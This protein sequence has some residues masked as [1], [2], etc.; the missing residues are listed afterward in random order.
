[1]PMSD[2]RSPGGA[3]ARMQRATRRLLSL[4]AKLVAVT[5]AVLIVVSASLFVGLVYRERARLVDAK[6]GAA[7]MLVQLLASELAAALDFGDTDSIKARLDDL[8]TNPDIVGAAVW[9]DA[10]SEPAAAW[11]APGAPPL[12]P[13]LS[14]DPD[15]ATASSEWL[16]ATRTIVGPR[17]AALA[18]ARV[19]FSLFPE[20][21]A[22]RRSRLRLFWLTAGL[23]AATAVVLALLARRYVVGPVRRLASAATALADGDLSVRVDS[24][25]ADEIGELARAFNVMGSAVAYREERLHKEIELAQRIQT[26]ILPANLTVPALE[27]AASM[28][29][30]SE[31]GG[32]YYD[33]LPVAGGSW[34]G[35]GDVAGH[36]L[37][38]GLMMLMIQAVVAG[39]V[40]RDPAS[41]PKEVL[42]TLNEVLFDNIR[43]RLKR[44]DHATLTLLSYR[45]DGTIA[46]AGAHEDIVVYRADRRVCEVVATPGTW[47]GGRRDIR[48][49]TVESTLKLDPGDVVLLHTD[50]ATEIRNSRGEPFGIER[51]CAGLERGAGK[52]PRELVE[53]L[54]LEVGA[55]GDAEDDVTIL[56]GKYS[57]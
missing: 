53:D 21:E 37:D 40:A 19:V 28:V 11:A 2:S 32:D 5:S 49:G 44:D 54:L 56:V 57:P 39:L 38:A 14:S 43:K 22:F 6:A 9:P 48:A 23:T 20:N 25:S 36:G 1:M 55:W 34:I 31:V 45:H 33:V 4:E 7:T 30:A 46:F 24:S 51:L 13:P 15:G 50:G 10:S 8:R 47:V 42:C 41:S 12:S 35:I 27:I 16:V 17:G 29:P 26:S 18:R 3:G 52:P